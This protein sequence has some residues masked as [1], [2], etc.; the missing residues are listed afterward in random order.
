MRELYR[1][2]K[3]IA[4]FSGKAAMVQIRKG[5]YFPQE[6]PHPTALY[7]EN[8]WPGIFQFGMVE[9]I[10]YNRCIAD[11]AVLTGPNKVIRI[12]NHSSIVTNSPES[13]LLFKKL[14]CNGLHSQ[15]KGNAKHLEDAEIWT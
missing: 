11:S 5:L 6:Q 2:A 4:V 3:P 13:A 7:D 8:P 12:K 9:Q 1:I 10:S 15:M 14:L